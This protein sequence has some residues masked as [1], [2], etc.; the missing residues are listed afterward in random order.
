MNEPSQII[1]G[2]MNNAQFNQ[3][4]MAQNVFKMYKEGDTQGLNQMAQNM[5]REKGIN[6][7]DAIKKIKLNFGIR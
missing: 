2:I 4:P 7:E 6:F 1:Q 5:C 3:N